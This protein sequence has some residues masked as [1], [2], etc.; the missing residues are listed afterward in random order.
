MGKNV[1]QR[2]ADAMG[3]VSYIQNEK[4]P[5]MQYRVVSHDKV[6]AKVRPA[7]LEVG[8]VY[9]PIRCD[10]V[11]SG[12]RTECS[13]TVRFVNVD[14]PADF[15]D[16]PTLG[17]GVDASDKG[18]GK[19]MSYAVKYALLKALGLETGE[20]PDEDADTPPH[21]TRNPHALPADLEPNWSATVA[22]DRIKLRFERAMQ[23]LDVAA[24][25]KAL[26]DEK[27]DLERL[28]AEDPPKRLE[29][30]AAYRE[31]AAR[32]K[33]AQQEQAA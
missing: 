4:K 22:R 8:I 10:Y 26:E 6:T 9:Y 29:C 30:D 18:P 16:V 25:K 20:D 7:L 33:A 11:Q 5:G 2:L 24:L 14:E 12:N 31:A 21:S 28:A 13:V 15:F 19:A 23:T 17:F 1:H 27:L 3:K 32:I